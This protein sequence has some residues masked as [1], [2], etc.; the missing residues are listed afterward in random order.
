M[1]SSNLIAVVLI[2]AIVAISVFPIFRRMAS[3]ETC[4]GEKKI[5]IKKKKLRNAVGSYV[6]DIEGMR[7][8]N[9]MREAT[10]AINAI[11]GVSGRVSLEKKQA[12]VSYSDTPKTDEVIKALGRIG[13]LGKPKA[14]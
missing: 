3:R 14:F 7:C 13:F 9:C 12:V 1:N 8:V 4:C 2:I 6:L 10:D 5:R 11:D